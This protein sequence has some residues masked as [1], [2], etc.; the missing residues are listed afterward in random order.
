MKIRESMLIAEE[1]RYLLVIGAMAEVQTAEDSCLGDAN[2]HKSY[3][4]GLQLK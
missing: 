3:S 2:D 1:S 4:V